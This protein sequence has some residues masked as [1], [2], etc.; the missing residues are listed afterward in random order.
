MDWSASF[1][2][3]SFLFGIALAVDAFTVSLA[4]SFADPTMKK[5]KHFLIAGT[6]GLFQGIMPFIGW[7]IFAG[8]SQI[9]NFKPILEKIIP[10]IALF[11]LGFLGVK[12][13]FE[14]RKKRKYNEPSIYNSMLKKDDKKGKIKTG[15]FI[16]L[17]VQAIGTSIDALTV[18]FDSYKYDIYHALVQCLIIA[19]MTFILCVIAIFIG[20]KIG[21]KIGPVALLIG[22]ILLIFIGAMIFTKGIL[23]YYCNIPV[24]F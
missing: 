15:F 1:F 19:M 22:G 2:L 13:I 14:Y 7:A 8:I 16:T 21:L 10:F 12:M 5:G 6:F 3:T 18:G 4:N 20:K 11:I 24:P 23:A 9:P 17:M